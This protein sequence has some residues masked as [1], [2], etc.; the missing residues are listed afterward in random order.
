V[1]VY[2]VLLDHPAI[3]ETVDIVFVNYY[4]YLEGIDI[5]FAVAALHRWHQQVVT[6]ANG[7]E[8]VVSET[9]W[10]S[11]GEP[12]GDAVPSLQNASEYFLNFVSWANANAVNYFYFEAFDEDW[13]AL[14]EGSQGAHWGVWDQDSN[15][16]VGM[17]AVFNGDAVEDNWSIVPIPGGEGDPVIEFVN[18]PALG[19]LDNLEGQVW[20]VD[21]FEH[22]VVVYINVSGWWIKPTYDLPFTV[23]Q[24]DGSWSCDITTGGMDET[25]TEIA[26]FLIPAVYQP[27]LL[28]GSLVLPEEL[29]SN[30]LDQVSVVR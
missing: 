25:A 3:I 16:K 6:A 17:E 30:S 21:P 26:A 13:K 4:P 29:Y 7:K 9:G 2:E 19:S 28:S 5:A 20:H 23:I 1:D 15:L 18:I 8:V 24:P 10:P 27:P 22:K 14:Y 12:Y 11:D